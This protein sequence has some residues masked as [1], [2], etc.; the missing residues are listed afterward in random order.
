MWKDYF[1]PDCRM[2]GVNI[3]Q[4]C[5]A[6]EQ[7]SIRILIGDQGSLWFWNMVREQVPEL[8][9]VTD[10]GSHVLDHQVVSL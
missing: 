7:E 6:Y 5:K 2:Y 10:D 8:D 4:D 9:I 1:G 3:R